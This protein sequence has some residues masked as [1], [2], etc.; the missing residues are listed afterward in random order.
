MTLSWLHKV[1]LRSQ[2]FHFPGSEEE[3]CTKRRSVASSGEAPRRGLAGRSP[4][5]PNLLSFKQLVGSL[6]F[7]QVARIRCSDNRMPICHLCPSSDCLLKGAL[8]LREAQARPETYPEIVF[9]LLCPFLL[10]FIHSPARTLSLC[11]SEEGW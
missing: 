10:F 7:I 11:H 2:E 4:R 9:Y 8:H 1:A 6:T 3:D 5:L